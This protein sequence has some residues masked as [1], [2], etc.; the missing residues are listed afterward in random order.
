MNKIKIQLGA[1]D[2]VFQSAD[3]L[4]SWLKNDFPST[5]KFR[6]AIDTF[7]SQFNEKYNTSVSF[8]QVLNIYERKSSLWLRENIVLCKALLDF[9]QTFWLEVMFS[10]HSDILRFSTLAKVD[11]TLQFSPL[12]ENHRASLETLAK[13]IS[14][15]I[16]TIKEY[17]RFI[18]TDKITSLQQTDVDGDFFTL[19]WIRREP[20]VVEVTDEWDWELQPV[21]VVPTSVKIHDGLVIPTNISDEALITKLSRYDNESLVV[22]FNY[23][24]D[25]IPYSERTG[26]KHND[27]AKKI[28]SDYKP[29]QWQAIER[30]LAKWKTLRLDTISQMDVWALKKFLLNWAPSNFWE[31]TV[32]LSGTDLQI[33]EWITISLADNEIFM[34]WVTELLPEDVQVLFWYLED[35][36]RTQLNVSGTV[37]RNVAQTVQI[38]RDEKVTTNIYQK[39][40]NVRSNPTRVLR[41]FFE[42][43]VDITKFRELILWKN[44]EVIDD[45]KVDWDWDWEWDDVQWAEGW[46]DMQ[47]KTFKFSFEE[48]WENIIFDID[49]SWGKGKEGFITALNSLIVQQCEKLDLQGYVEKFTLQDF[50]GIALD[51]AFFTTIQREKSETKLIEIFDVIDEGVLEQFLLTWHEQVG[52]KLKESKKVYIEPGSPEEL[53]DFVFN[54]WQEKLNTMVR[55]EVR[56]SR[57]SQSHRGMKRKQTSTLTKEMF[58]NAKELTPDLFDS[59][60]NVGEKFQQIFSRTSKKEVI[61]WIR[62]YISTRNKRK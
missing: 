43:N 33:R 45:W 53:W 19:P 47:K 12:L 24:Y 8:E 21:K 10:E 28:F 49:L 54:V 41:R 62:E 5:K 13:T 7:F 11:A 58:W 4:F 22:I 40:T 3:K 32:Y 38:G 56:K 25:R 39:I 57:T 37:A 15:F 60:P 1:N 29:H 35:I 52:K 27:I 61:S 55:K 59:I 46:A 17:F 6:E 23:I 16:W 26:I 50:E 31:K 30:V 2:N 51:S 36:V 42:N 9:I 44:I 48:E 34:D 20:D 14:E 18:L